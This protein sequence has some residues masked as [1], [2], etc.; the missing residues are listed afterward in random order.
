MA[1]KPTPGAAIKYKQWH[2]PWMTVVI[3]SRWVT[4]VI[5][6]YMFLFISTQRRQMIRTSTRK[7]NFDS[8][9]IASEL[10]PTACLPY[11]PKCWWFR[12]NQ[13]TLLMI[14]LHSTSYHTLQQSYLYI[15][16]IYVHPPAIIM[17]PIQ[18]IVNKTNRLLSSA[19]HTCAYPHTNSNIIPVATLSRQPCP[20]RSIKQKL[21]HSA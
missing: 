8:H 18:I 15:T 10:A 3:M 11:F 21:S 7:H 9:Y 16:I 4:N 19:R 2:L 14:F 20:P 17:Y 12:T 1:S 13:C 5:S 6:G